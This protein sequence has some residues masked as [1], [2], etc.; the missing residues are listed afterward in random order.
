MVS[1]LRRARRL[2]DM[3]RRLRDRA[4]TVREL[5]EL[6]NVSER[7]IRADI[8]ELQ[9]EPFYLPAMRRV[10]TMWRIGDGKG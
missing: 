8:L 1:H 3:V 5:A 4:Y 10:V 2:M 9:G 7:T 6:Y